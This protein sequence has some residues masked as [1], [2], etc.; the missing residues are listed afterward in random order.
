MELD[1][2]EIQTKSNGTT[3]AQLYLNHRGG[4]VAIAT[5][6][7]KVLLGAG[8]YGTTLPSSGTTGQIFFLKE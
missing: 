4:N 5:G 7:G 2:N 8:A 6:G 3:A 1:T